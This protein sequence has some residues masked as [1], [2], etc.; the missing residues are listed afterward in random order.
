M[1]LILLLI[2]I[3]FLVPTPSLSFSGKNPRDHVPSELQWSL[4]GD[5]MDNIQKK[6][7]LPIRKKSKQAIYYFD[8]PNSDL[9]KNQIT[10]RLRKSPKGWTSDL[11]SSYEDP[12]DMPD[13]IPPSMKCEKNYYR[14]SKL[15]SCTSQY[16]GATLEAPLSKTQEQV[17]QSK[18]MPHI[19]TRKLAPQGPFERIK[20]TMAYTVPDSQDKKKTQ[21]W[22]LDS[23]EGHIE[24]SLRVPRTSDDFYYEQTSQVL[25][26]KGL[27]LCPEQKGRLTKILKN[28]P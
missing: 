26:E 1:K 3:V 15:V 17:I 2:G 27:T 19:D 5:S 24:L 28:A 10:L 14:D 12:R 20:V 6:L 4:C 13:F 16:K 11:K 9:L 21:T 25:K 8:T 18:I 23:V 7:N 22:T